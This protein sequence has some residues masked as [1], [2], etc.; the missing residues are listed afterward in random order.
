MPFAFKIQWI[1][2]PA[3]I[4]LIPDIRFAP[5]GKVK[6]VRTA[7]IS[8]LHVSELKFV[9]KRIYKVYFTVFNPQLQLR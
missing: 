3:D 6:L 1:Q 2:G 4:D 5:D 8:G 9:S 7:V